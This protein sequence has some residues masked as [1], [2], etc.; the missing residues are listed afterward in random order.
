[1]PVK[2]KQVASTVQHLRGKGLLFHFKISGSAVT[3]VADGAVSRLRN[4]LV[5]GPSARKRE[6]NR[7]SATEE[8]HTL[9]HDMP[10]V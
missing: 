7:E 5:E 8:C 2:R 10:L 9:S 4:A 3:C 6:A 1:M